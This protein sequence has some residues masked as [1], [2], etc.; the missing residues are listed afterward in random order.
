MVSHLVLSLAI[1]LIV[2]RLVAHAERQPSQARLVLG[3]I[4]AGFALTILAVG[5]L[6]SAMRPVLPWGSMVVA[7]ALAVVLA[8]SY[9]A[10]TRPGIRH[11]LVSVT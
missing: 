2:V 7:N 6:T 8:G 1:G 4:V 5:W 11:R 3:V 10:R 9:L